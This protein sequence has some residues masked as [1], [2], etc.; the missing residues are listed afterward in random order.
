VSSADQTARDLRR[1]IL[2]A[3]GA[4]LTA[5]RDELVTA[6]GPN[7]APRPDSQIQPDQVAQ[8]VLVHH[9]IEALP[10]L[11]KAAPGDAIDLRVTL[12]YALQGAIGL[13]I[14]AALVGFL[15]RPLYGLVLALAGGAAIAVMAARGDWI[16]RR[17]PRLIPRGR[18]LGAALAAIPVFLAGLAVILPLRA[19]YRHGSNAGGAARLVREAD[20]AIDHGDFDTAKR[21]LFEAESSAPNPPAIGD[22]RAHLVVAQV[23]SVI[24]D[25]ARKD[26]IYAAAERAFR[27]HRLQQAMTLMRSIS[28]WKDAD[29]RAGAFKRGKLG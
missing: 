17:T 6:L 13:T 9:G 10:A 8:A 29:A 7:G 3:P 14:A 21:K 1:R 20:A 12:R 11:P 22:V 19:H 25:A 18:I 26:A 27:G 2:A 4:R 23:Q 24:D 5:P 15:G 16:E 28:G